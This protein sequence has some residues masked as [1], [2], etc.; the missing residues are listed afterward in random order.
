M[1]KIQLKGETSLAPV[2]A[3]LVTSA[4]DGKRDVMTVAWTGTINSA[5]PMTYVSIRKSRYSHELISKSREFVINLTT[6]QMAQITDF[7]GVVSGKVADKFEK[8]GIECEK[9][10]VVGAPLIKAS[11]LCLECKVTDVVELG[12]HDMFIAEIVAV[13]AD[14][15]IINADGRPDLGKADLIA[16]IQG[17]YFRIGE[18]IGRFGF[19]VEKKK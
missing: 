3:M 14:E 11:P 16:Y 1:S 19:S 13:D 6:E 12:S 17:Q 9:A 4:A 2:P 15:K 18:K 10:A 7:C 8:C 5:P